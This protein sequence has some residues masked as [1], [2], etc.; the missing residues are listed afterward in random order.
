MGV[1]DPFCHSEAIVAYG[2]CP[3]AGKPLVDRF[4]VW[5]QGAAA[6]WLQPGGARVLTDRDLRGDRPWVPQAQASQGA[7]LPA[8]LAE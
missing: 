1:G 8:A 3:G 5:R 4:T 2:N 6:I 7:E